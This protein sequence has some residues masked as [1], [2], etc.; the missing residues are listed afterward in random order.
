M[1]IGPDPEEPTWVWGEGQGG[2]GIQSAPADGRL[3]ADLSL[4]AAPPWTL[5]AGIDVAALAPGRL[6]GGRA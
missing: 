3:T 2:N 6:S 1:L 4:G 5:D